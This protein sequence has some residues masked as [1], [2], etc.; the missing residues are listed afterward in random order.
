MTTDEIMTVAEYTSDAELVS[1]TLAGDQDAFN[2]IVSRYQILICSRLAAGSATSAKA[3]MWLRKLLHHR[4]EAS[5][6]LART[7]KIAF[8]AARHRD[9]TEATN[10]C[11]A[12][13]RQPVQNAEPL[14]TAAE[15]LK[16]ARRFSFGANQHRAR[17]RSDLC[18]VRWKGF[19]SCI[20]NRLILFYREHQ[21]IEHVAVELELTEDTAKQRLSRG[22]KLLQEEVLTFVER[23]LSKS[24]Q[25][26]GGLFQPRALRA[27]FGGRARRLQPV[28]EWR[29]K[30]LRRRNQGCFRCSI[31]V[32]PLIG[33]F[34][35]FAAQWLMTQDVPAPER[36]A[37]R[38]EMLRAWIL[39]GGLAFGGPFVLGNLSEHFK[40]SGRTSFEAATLFYWFFGML[41]ATVLVSVYR[42]IPLR[43]YPRRRNRQ[44][45]STG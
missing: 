20:A 24:A 12:K 3:R 16:P 40:W 33:I 18:G 28:P 21:S 30:G 27:A 45:I 44:A 36:R 41:V 11:N 31:F 6:P 38:I 23:A 10:A 13:R 29:A 42:T 1:R 7:G 37:R 19:Q 2:R 8:L 26:H 14:E 17:R 9:A 32:A 4:V 43:A 34:T 15:L 5:A 22:R 25:A 35:G 39:F